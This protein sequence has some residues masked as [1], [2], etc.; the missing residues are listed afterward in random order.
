M[1]NS[2]YLDR[3]LVPLA[4]APHAGGHRGKTRHGSASR[5]ARAS[6]KS[7]GAWRVDHADI[8]N[9]TLA[10]AVDWAGSAIPVRPSQ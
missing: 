5:K 3:P 8:N 1:K 2:P 4:V 6:T 10:L 7:R 9:P